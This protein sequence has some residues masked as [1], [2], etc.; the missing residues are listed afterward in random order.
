MK[1]YARLGE[2]LSDTGADGPRAVAG[3]LARLDGRPFEQLLAEL[4][5]ANLHQGLQGP[6]TSVV[7]GPGMVQ[8]GG[9]RLR[10]RS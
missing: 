9:T 3:L 1:L 5:V 4:E 7:L 2:R 8:V 10:T 6:S